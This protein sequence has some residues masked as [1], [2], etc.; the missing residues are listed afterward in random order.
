M[1]KVTIIILLVLFFILWA[2][3]FYLSSSENKKI[4]TAKQSELSKYSEFYHSEIKKTVIA[5]EDK[6]NVTD[7]DFIDNLKHKSDTYKTLKIKAEERKPKN[8]DIKDIHQELLSYLDFKAKE[9]SEYYEYLNTEDETH[10]RKYV[11]YK[12]DAEKHFDL[13]ERKLKYHKEKE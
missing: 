7:H 12:S 6:N 1:K 13:F 11:Q 9:N 5:L 3:G 2:I 10:Y 8:G 4:E